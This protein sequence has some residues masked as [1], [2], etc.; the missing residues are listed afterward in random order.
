MCNTKILN[1]SPCPLQ[2]LAVFALDYAVEVYNE[3]AQI[4]AKKHHRIL[5]L[6]ASGL[7]H[8]SL[9]AFMD[10]IEARTSKEP[11]PPKMKD[12]RRTRLVRDPEL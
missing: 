7:L 3:S 12:I 1:N 5:I 10:S 9:S 8:A 6:F 2:A 4:M 11:T